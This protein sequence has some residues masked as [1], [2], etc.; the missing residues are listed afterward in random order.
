MAISRSHRD[1]RDKTRAEVF[2]FKGQRDEQENECCKDK[3]L[4]GKSVMWKA[5]IFI[6]Y[7]L[8]DCHVLIR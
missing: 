6:M 4:L 8:A 1:V 3:R 2:T 7:K 5:E